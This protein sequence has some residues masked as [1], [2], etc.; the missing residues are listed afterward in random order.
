MHSDACEQR[1]S[2]ETQ[3]RNDDKTQ[4]EVQL[5]QANAVAEQ[6]RATHQTA[7]HQTAEMTDN[8]LL[9]KAEKTKT[10]AE[11]LRLRAQQAD[12]PHDSDTTLIDIYNQ[13]IDDVCSQANSRVAAAASQTHQAQEQLR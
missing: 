11:V 7:L 2:L 5:L 3:T 9:L 4:F 8:V 1:V 10:D 6:Y 12:V 13:T